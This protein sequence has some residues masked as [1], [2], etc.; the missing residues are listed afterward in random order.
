MKREGVTP[1]LTH[2]QTL[3][4]STSRRFPERIHRDRRE[5]GGCQGLRCD[6]MRTEPQS[7]KM[8][9]LGTVVPNRGDALNAAEPH[10]HRRLRRRTRIM[11][12][13]K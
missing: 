12:F 2:T 6:L 7:G 8:S 3:D 5:K 13:T 10:T 9:K 11:R 1:R 4:G